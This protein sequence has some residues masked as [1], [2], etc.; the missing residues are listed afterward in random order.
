MTGVHGVFTGLDSSI[1]GTMKFRD[2]SVVE[3]EGVGIVF[4]IC[5]NREH[6]SL[7]GVYLI[8]KLTTNIISLGQLDEIRYEMI[9]RGGLM[10][11]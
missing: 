8:L 2:G 3:I 4:F 9:I 5:K 11:V 6:R 1:W 7:T 10:R